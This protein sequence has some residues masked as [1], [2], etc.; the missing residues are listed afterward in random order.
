MIP[1][2]RMTEQQADKLTELSKA[3]PKTGRAYRIAAAFDDM[4]ACRTYG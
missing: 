1:E 2:S 4:Y 3:Y